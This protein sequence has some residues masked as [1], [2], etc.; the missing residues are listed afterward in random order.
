MLPFVLLALPES[1]RVEEQLGEHGSLLIQWTA[2]VIALAGALL[3]CWTVAFAPDGTSSRDTRAA[4][5]ATLNTTGVY[6]IVRHP[7]YLGSGLMW[8]GVALSLRVWWLVAI[9]TLA[10]GLY[11]ERLMAFEE[12]FLASTFGDDFRRWA[13]QTP[14][15]IPGIRGWV[16]SRGQFQWRRVLSEHNGTLAVLLMIPLFQLLEDTL[17]GESLGEWYSEHFD[18]VVMLAT[19]LSISVIAITVRR[20]PDAPDGSTALTPHST[21]QPQA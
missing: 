17:G 1:F 3:R 9:A 7:L 19:A 10:Y 14:A 12:S 5:A 6:S 13:A 16:P 8:V 18:L 4:R 20:L 2:L 21:D 15:I 11:L